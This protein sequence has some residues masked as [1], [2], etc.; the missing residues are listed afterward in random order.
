[1]P[2]RSVGSTHTVFVIES[3]IDELA[4]VHKTDPLKYRQFLLKDHPRHLNVL[5]KAAE[6]AEWDK[7]LPHG[8][9]RGISVCEAMGTYL[10]QV[11]EI[12]IDTNRIR[13]HRVV[14]AIDCGIAVNPDNVRAQIEG[15]IIFGLSAAL[16][17]E[18]TITKGQVAQRNFNDYKM[19]RINETP[20]I[21]VH[22]I[23][24]GEP[25][26]GVGEPGVAPI[27]AAVAN[28][29]ASATGKRVRK[30]PIRLDELE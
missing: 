23:D 28:A 14:C 6:K 17:G 18:I 16:Y 5:N 22:I 10:S 7:P 4:H 19:L 3:L 30:L 26:G 2:W 9:F 15:G 29:I 8:I 27:A 11:T 20:S 21:E 24:S 12:S 1:M 25:P 13:V